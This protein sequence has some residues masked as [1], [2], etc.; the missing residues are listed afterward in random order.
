M[1]AGRSGKVYYSRSHLDSNTINVL[2]VFVLINDTQ[3]ARHGHGST[4][5]PPHK[6]EGYE[7]QRTCLVR[8]ENSDE[9]A[10]CSLWQ[11]PRHDHDLDQAWSITPRRWPTASVDVLLH[12]DAVASM[13]VLT[14]KSQAAATSSVPPALAIAMSSR[15]GRRTVRARAPLP[16]AYALADA[17]AGLVFLNYLLSS[18]SSSY[19]EGSG[20]KTH[21]IRASYRLG[22]L[23]FRWKEQPAH[24]AR[25]RQRLAG[26]SSER[27]RR[28]LWT[29]PSARDCSQER[30][31]EPHL[32]SRR[33][34]QHGE[35]ELPPSFERRRRVQE[36]W[37]ST[38]QASPLQRRDLIRN[39]RL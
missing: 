18:L 15:T 39:K 4:C 38:W 8:S 29:R 28:H 16:R 3:G 12:S 5:K 31:C 6:M 35:P 32:Q 9:T 26:I 25:P 37:C 33:A 23:G 34:R 7:R 11:C 19:N 30:V 27:L 20:D 22:R 24:E 2:Y 21:F 36:A 10:Q 13:Q 1:S 17:L 14:G